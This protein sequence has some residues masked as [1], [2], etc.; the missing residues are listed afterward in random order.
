MILLAICCGFGRGKATK[1][2]E[3]HDRTE[4]S[5]VSNTGHYAGETG[6]IEMET[7]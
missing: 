5:Q 7:H 4:E 3:M 6:E 2:N 1:F